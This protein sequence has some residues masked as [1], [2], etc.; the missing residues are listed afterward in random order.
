MAQG[1]NVANVEAVEKFR[2]SLVTFC[3]QAMDALSAVQMEARRTTD[4]I[5]ND[6]KFHW[7]RQL[8]I[9]WDDLAS[10]K[11]ALARKELGKS[12][13]R[14]V[15]LTEEKKNL[16][17]AQIR[18]EEAQQKIEAVQRWSR[19]LVRA[20]DEYEAQGRQLAGLIEGNPSRCVIVMDN[21]LEALENYLKLSPPPSIANDPV[22]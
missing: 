11:A 17:I 5:T 6:R 18:L 2:N 12:P 13:E 15:D 4:W 9:R 20:I 16:R 22:A 19:V 8:R 21:I 14:N 10:A 7:E 1:A 3:E